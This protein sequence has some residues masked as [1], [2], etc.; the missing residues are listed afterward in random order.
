[1]ERGIIKW[2]AF[3]SVT[4]TKEMLHEEAKNTELIPMPILSEEQLNNIEN[5][6]IFGFYSAKILNI[7]YYKNGKIYIKNSTIKKI[8]SA[9]Q[10][11]TLSDNSI[12]LF[13]QIVKIQ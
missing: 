7:H 1:M 3:N 5:T 9:M 8:D 12:L 2:R 6:L 11:I 4:N 10:T 13:K